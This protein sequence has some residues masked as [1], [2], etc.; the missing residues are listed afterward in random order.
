M[1]AVLLALA[2][3]I[4][5]AA[6]PQKTVAVPVER[7]SIMLITDV[8]GSM[9]ATD[10][11]PTRLVAARLYGAAERLREQMGFGLGWFATMLAGVMRGRQ[12]ADSS[13]R[14]AY[15]CR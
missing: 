9:Q 6:R 12:D 4:L 15:A 13:A 10:V 2:I 1:L 5:A 3:L 14:C 8:S 11:R 7:A